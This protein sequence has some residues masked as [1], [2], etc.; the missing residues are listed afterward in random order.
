M[1][2]AEH[3]KAIRNPVSL[4]MVGCL[5]FRDNTWITCEPE[6]RGSFPR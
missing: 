3:L 5:I 2:S 1:E 4:A 6:T